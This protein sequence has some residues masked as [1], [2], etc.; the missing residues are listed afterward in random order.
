[1]A[2]YRYIA[3]NPAGQ[4]LEGL[5]SAVAKDDVFC[6]LKEQGLTPLSVDEPSWRI[7]SLKK[8]V[9]GK[10]IRSSQLAAVFWQLNTMLEGG[11]PLTEALAAVAEDIA[12]KRLREV[13]EG[14]LQQIRKG[15]DL[16]QGVSAFPKVFNP[17]VRALI[18]AGETSGELSDALGRVAKHY[19]T[20]DQLRR[21]VVKAMVYPAFVIAFVM[22][23]VSVLMIFVIPRFR[24]VF[25]EMGGNIPAFTQAYMN[26]YD[27]LVANMPYI[28][29]V[30]VLTVLAATI[31]H[32]RTKRGHLFFS[33][34]S[35]RI[36]LI[37]RV[38][39]QAFVV[40]YCRT[41]A[42]L[43]SAGVPV[44]DVFEILRAM[45][46][47]DITRTAVIHTNEK[48]I[49]GSGIAEGMT[50]SKFFPNMVVKMVQSGEKSGALPKVL[51]KTGD[52]YEEQM[53]A[54][55]ATLITM[56]EPAMIIIFGVIVFVTVLAL[57]LP[58]IELSNIKG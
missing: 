25:V 32:R 47:N 38:L 55:I 53:D 19:Q 44:L 50:S 39:K 24:E 27:G 16:S 51:D 42:N 13:L 31:L 36:P 46:T 8:S 41:M 29:I 30:A 17:L 4:E 43:L 37:G 18:V 9:G 57:Y 14:V 23:V 40:R 26:F 54:T 28:A 10:R 34:L 11:I 21:K 2:K 52:Y 15:G 3:K 48:V 45:T 1:M 20:R 58:V 33:K 12:N 22:V 56:L 35:L 49:E 6:W 5:A 7:R